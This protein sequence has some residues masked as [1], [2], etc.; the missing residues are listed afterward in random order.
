M[1]ARQVTLE[2]DFAGLRGFLRDLGRLDHRVLVLR[3]DITVGDGY[4]P[5]VTPLLATLVVVF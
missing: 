5:G 3:F 4:R 2:T 1:A